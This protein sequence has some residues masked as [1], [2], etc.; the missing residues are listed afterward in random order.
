MLVID[1]NSPDGTATKVSD[2][3]KQYPNLGL[4]SRSRK[5]GLGAAYKHAIQYVLDK[6]NVG[7][8]IMMDA[9]GSH[10]VEYIEKML[11]ECDSYDFV[12]G[13][14]YVAGGG[15]EDWQLSRYL[16]SLYGNLYS[17][18]LTGLQVRDQTAGF[19]CF[20]GD[21]LR[22]MDMDSIRASGYAFQV[23]LKYH[24]IRERGAS[25]KEIPILFKNRRAGESKISS[26]IIREG[27]KTPLRLFGRRIRSIFSRG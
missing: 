5:E 25:V 8:I 16:L 13:S 22:K 10:G 12:I 26:A 15:S 3:M 2:L 18:I 27:L 6:G 19:Y 17:R 14:R 23:D 11:E 7:K 4:L 24:A 9:D 1:D 20:R 21:L